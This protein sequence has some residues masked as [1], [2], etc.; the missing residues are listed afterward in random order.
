MKNKSLWGIV[1]L[2]LLSVSI[3]ISSDGGDIKVIIKEWEVPTPNSRPH[4]P[5]IDPDGLLWY[6]GQQV[7]VLGRLDPKT[8]K[9]KEYLLKVPNS[10]PHGLVADKEGNI[11]FTANY[12]G[13]IGKMNP[14]TGA[15]D[16]ISAS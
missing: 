4:D 13:Y 5:A 10:G 1:F 11:W 9:M 2:I 8:G 12:K 16:R 3:P 15:S 6:T 14:L 7:N